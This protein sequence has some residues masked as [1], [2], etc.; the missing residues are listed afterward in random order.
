MTLQVPFEGFVKAVEHFASVRE[1]FVTKH[2]SGCLVTAANPAKG[3]H[4]SAVS[5][6]PTESVRSNLSEAGLK[7]FD[8]VWSLDGELETQ[9]DPLS[10]CHVAAVS[11]VSSNHVPGVWIDAYAEAPNHVHV[12]RMMYE[13][14]R[15]TGELPDVSIEEF[16]RLANPNVITVSAAQ[17]RTFLEEKKEKPC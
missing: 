4:I 11:Y 12:L 6:L 3:V 1:V 13:E 5:D 14:F 8:G 7:V 10:T 17:L 9:V 15:E 2:V 16:V